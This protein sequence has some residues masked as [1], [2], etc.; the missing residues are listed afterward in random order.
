MSLSTAIEPCNYSGFFDLEFASRFGYVDWD[1][2]N[3]KHQ[4][5][6]TAPMTCEESLVRAA[7]QT[8]R[9]NPATKVFIYRNLV[10]ALPVSTVVVV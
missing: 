7:E 3:A 9:R 8:H 2:S 6:N 4:W 5:A 1:W 10:K